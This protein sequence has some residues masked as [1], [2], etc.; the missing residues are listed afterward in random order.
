[1]IA[2]KYNIEVEETERTQEQISQD[3]EKESLFLVSD[4]MKVRYQLHNKVEFLPFQYCNKI[5]VFQLSFLM[6]R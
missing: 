4:L 2:N 5:R 3:N 6:C 1:M